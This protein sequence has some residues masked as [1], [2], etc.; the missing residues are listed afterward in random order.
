MTDSPTAPPTLR[1]E[2]KFTCDS[3]WLTQARSWIRQHPTAF[4]VAY[5]PRTVNSLYL[6]TQGL[7]MLQANLSGIGQRQKLRLRWY[8][9]TPSNPTLELKYKDNLLGGKHQ[10]KLPITLDLAQP[11]PA[12]FAAL[13]P[14]LTPAW[15][16]LLQT[17]QRPVLMNRYR[18]EYYASYDGQIRVTLDYD[19]EAFDQQFGNRPNLHT[20]ILMQPPIVLE[21]KADDAQ[22]ERL[23]AI[24]AYFPIPRTRNSKYA[25]SLL[26]ALYAI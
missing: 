2:L 6:D 26:T 9:D 23:Q 19:Q 17:Y 22:T 1:Y 25:N 3:H 15:Q 10:H 24:A 11:W 12:L 5:P 18:R 21:L 4:R 8:N 16:L 20:P 7:N 14:H 13:Q